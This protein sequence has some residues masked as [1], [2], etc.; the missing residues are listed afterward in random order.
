MEN[1]TIPTAETS[2]QFVF[3]YICNHLIS[4]MPGL[5]ETQPYPDS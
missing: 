1:F 2:A 3:S 5:C 4:I